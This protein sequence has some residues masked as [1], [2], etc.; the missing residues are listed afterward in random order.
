MMT[1]RRV[2]ITLFGATGDLAKRKLYPAL[3]RLFKKG[4]LRDHFAVIG[5]ARREWNDDFLRQVVSESV[6]SLSDDTALISAFVSHFYYLAHNVSNTTEYTHLKALS[7]TLDAKYALENNRI[8]YLAM[9]PQFFGI[10]AEN[11]KSQHLLTETGF[12]RLIIEK[13]FGHNL[14]TAIELN[15]QLAKSFDEN[16]IYRIDHYLG[17]EMV[18]NIHALRYSNILFDALWNNQYID[19][20]QI[21]L[22]E[23]VGVEE[24][25]GY[26]DQSGALRDMI[27]NHAFQILSLLAMERPVRM[28]GEEIRHEKA[29]ALHAL[30][31][32][33]PEEIKEN[34]IRGQY[35]AGNGMIGYL[36]EKDI[37]PLSR[38]E[39][40]VAGKVLID[41]FRWAGVPFYIR[42]GKRLESK[43][44]V[45]HIQF[46]SVPMHVFN[47][48]TQ[49]EIFPNVLTIHIQPNQRMSLNLNMKSTGLS[50]IIVREHLLNQI[51]PEQELDIPEAYERLILECLDG[52]TGNFAHR[53]EV[54]LSW[55]YI[56]HIRKAWDNDTTTPLAVYPAGSMG[57]T[58]SF[59]LLDEDKFFWHNCE[60]TTC[61]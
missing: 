34:F 10:I 13:P 12:N 53:E 56:D 48:T 44:T 9:A 58:E 33:S 42:T 32:Y 20:V 8:F 21:T 1:E 6:Q 27:Q 55:K 61:F 4:H 22:A 7:E 39:T 31:F 40:F 36:E 37:D 47:Q 35:A 11:L 57:P 19:N 50:N 51:T 3:F 38:T 54:E 23:S 52:N 45:I 17:K 14:E 5:T 24:R 29:K 41:N 25:A 43:D 59:N 18:Q 30:R 2:L 28:S 15:D 60:T 46:K 49:P 26:Y 16:Q